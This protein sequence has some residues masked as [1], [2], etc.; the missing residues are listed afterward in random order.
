[1]NTVTDRIN[2]L[3][4]EATQTALD[5]AYFVQRQ[6]GQFIQSWYNTLETNRQG[7]KEIVTRGIRQ[8]QEG[9]RLWLQLTQQWLRTATE[10]AVQ[11]AQFGLEE[12]SNGLD[13]AQ[14]QTNST[15]KKAEAAS[16]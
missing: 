7:A 14:A 11:S 3:A 10:T 12:V 15:S 8:A 5:G 13:K 4:I 16:K 1:M 9:Q 2:D 6:N